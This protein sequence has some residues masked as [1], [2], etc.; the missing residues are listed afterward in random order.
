KDKLIEQM[1]SALE[2]AKQD[3]L[4]LSEYYLD[5]FGD[6]KDKDEIQGWSKIKWV[7]ALRAYRKVE[8]A[9][10]AERGG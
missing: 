8:A 4:C 3:S 9:L 10:A 6:Y 7:K 5:T 2:A 1:R